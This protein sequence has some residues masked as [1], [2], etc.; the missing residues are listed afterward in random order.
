M[1]AYPQVTAG[2][3]AG[4]HGCVTG[5]GLGRISGTGMDGLFCRIAITIWNVPSG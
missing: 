3:Q 5:S 2:A 4:G 1:I